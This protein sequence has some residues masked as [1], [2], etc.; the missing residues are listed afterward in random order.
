MPE[1]LRLRNFGRPHDTFCGR[2]LHAVLFFCANGNSHWRRRKEPSEND[3]F[4]EKDCPISGILVQV[5][6]F[7]R[8]IAPFLPIPPGKG[9]CESVRN[10]KA[11]GQGLTHDSKQ[12]I[13]RMPT[14]FCQSNG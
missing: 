4:S 6:Q 1:K 7:R 2:I 13:S 9:W 12:E 3:N 5:S 10:V 14:F 11:C 8:D